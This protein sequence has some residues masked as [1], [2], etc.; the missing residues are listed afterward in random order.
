MK[1]N[2]DTGILF[3]RADWKQAEDHPDY[4]GHIVVGSETLPVIGTKR[5]GDFG[6]SITI[7]VVRWET[8]YEN[9]RFYGMTPK[10]AET[11]KLGEPEF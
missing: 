1:L 11:A 4:A 9:P 5:N 7:N 10:Q 8:V 3:D 6:E 2:P